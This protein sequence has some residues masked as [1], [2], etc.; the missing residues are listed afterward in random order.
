MSHLYAHHPM[1][2][3]L[4]SVLYP[5]SL[6]SACLLAE[7]G[8]RWRHV[9]T[10]I[11]SSLI[12]V[13]VYR[14][15]GSNDA[16]ADGKTSAHVDR[17]YTYQ[18]SHR[19]VHSHFSIIHLPSSDIYSSVSFL[20]KAYL[21]IVSRAAAGIHSAHPHRMYRLHCLPDSLALPSSGLALPP[22]THHSFFPHPIYTDSYPIRLAFHPWT[23]QLPLN[24]PTSSA[25]LSSTHHYQH[26]SHGQN[27]APRLEPQQ[28]IHTG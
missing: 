17:A 18:Q 11:P 3:T 28:A 1:T 23:L 4:P 14:L 24:P 27:V 8:C 5:P 19:D 15:K 21:Y 7:L 20:N 9:G 6:S 10:L 22:L 12:M 13:R 2:W 26:G 25:P 16:A